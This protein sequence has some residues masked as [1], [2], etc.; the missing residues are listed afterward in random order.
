L[1]R[2]RSSIAVELRD[3]RYLLLDASP[4]LY[5]QL[6][7]AGLH[8]RGQ[9]R[10]SVIEAILLTHGHGD[11]CIGLFELSTG[12]IFETPVY[13]PPDLIEHLFGEGSYFSYLG[14]L[15]ERYVEPTPL[16]KGESLELPGGLRAEG[17][18]VPH[19]E[20]LEDGSY[21]PSRTYGYELEEDERRLLYI[22]DVKELAEEVAERMERADLVL[23]DG[24]F[25]WEDELLRMS[26]IDISSSELG[27]IPIERSLEA[28][29]GMEVG[30]VLFTH[31]NH[32][33]P[34]LDPGR[35]ML[36][37]LRRRGFDV[38]YDGLTLDL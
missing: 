23:L 38:A 24:T 22:P 35:R 8:P 14:R 18:E 20:R 10:E 12:A 19:T 4:D 28:L 32:T 31:I 2:T 7:T 34:L 15:G 37:E 29:R 21:I 25:W 33:N 36:K 27:H 1:R 9:G 6:Y 16:M 17:F 13:G 3:G 26:G 30:K 11:H 5:H